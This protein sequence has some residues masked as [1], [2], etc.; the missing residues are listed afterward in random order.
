MSANDPIYPSPANVQ[1]MVAV[2]SICATLATVFV[3]LRMYAKWRYVNL[4]LDDLFMF[5]AAVSRIAPLAE[6]G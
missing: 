3:C 1:A 5:G 2:C 6:R 4:M